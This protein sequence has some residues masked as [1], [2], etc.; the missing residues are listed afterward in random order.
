MGCG[1]WNPERVDGVVS[2]GRGRPSA[3]ETDMWL[4]V[5]GTAWCR[6]QVVV[7]I[8]ARGKHCRMGWQGMLIPTFIVYRRLG[9]LTIKA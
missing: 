4:A 5:P 1:I 3:S 6:Q 2:D 7:G 9:K 8:V